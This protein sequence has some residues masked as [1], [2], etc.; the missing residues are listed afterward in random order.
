MNKRTLTQAIV[1]Y[2]R[3]QTN[4]ESTKQNRNNL[5]GDW[6]TKKIEQKNGKLKKNALHTYTRL[7]NILHIFFVKRK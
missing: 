5:Y 4:K 2:E 7:A 6:R 3:K 1:K